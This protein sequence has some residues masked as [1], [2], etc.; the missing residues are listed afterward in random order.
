MPRYSEKVH[1]WIPL[2]FIAAH[3]ALFSTTQFTYPLLHKAM[4]FDKKSK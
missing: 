1:N 4:F 2:P 3:H